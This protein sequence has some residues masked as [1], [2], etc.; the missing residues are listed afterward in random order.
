[1][2]RNPRRILIMAGGTGGHV[3][4]ALAVARY[5]EEQGVEIHWLGTR[6]GL[7]S[8]VVPRAGFSIRFIS[9]SGLRGKRLSGLFFAPFKL[10]YAL[11]QAIVI[12]LRLKPDA[13]LGMGGFVTGPGGLAAWLLRRPLLIHEQNAIPGLTNRLLS[14]LALQV[15]EA[16][17]GSFKN[18]RVLHTGNPVRQDIIDLSAP[19][20]RLPRHEGAIRILVIGGSLGAQV[21]NETVPQALSRLPDEIPVT[22]RHQAGR[23][24]LESAREA[25]ASAG[26]QA[27]TVMFID[28]M[29][30]A[31][32]WA[33]LVICRAG[34][35]T[36]FELASAGLASV[37]V[38]YP[39]AVDDHQT[40]NARYL[41]EAGAAR[42]MPARE[43]NAERL[44]AVLRELLEQGR[45]NLLAM[46]ERARQRAMPDAT[47][48]V[49]QRCLEVMH[50]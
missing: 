38:P 12:C 50:G 46:A 33:D 40:A 17:P 15:M 25:Y 2:N 29:A 27:E 14:H 6:R 11:L 16:F 42:L 30:D 41:E 10:S 8:Q 24:K 39:Y 31:F 23:G 7:E 28:D 47:R 44:A 1:M 4:P 9:V 26:I 21:L 19:A 45:D 48:I 35:L 13:V 3:F 20:Q 18:D 36:V 22:V 43:F 32:E 49:G 34:A 37:L 5:L